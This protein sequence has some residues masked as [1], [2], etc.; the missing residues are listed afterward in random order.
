MYGEWNNKAA[1]IVSYGSAGGARAA[2][3]LRRLQRY[4]GGE[5]QIADVRAQVMLS[6]V[7]DF[8]ELLRVRKLL[9]HEAALNMLLN[10]V[11]SWSTALEG[12]RAAA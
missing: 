10:Q 7:D 8:E 4:P 1:G 9:H 12:V 6:L 11:N 3:H 5:L 2:E